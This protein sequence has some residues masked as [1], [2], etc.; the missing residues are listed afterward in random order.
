MERKS[1]FVESIQ[2]GRTLAGHLIRCLALLRK[3]IRQGLESTLLQPE[4][5][6]DAVTN[7]T[8]LSAA[9]VS[10]FCVQLL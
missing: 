8:H 4:E 5:L 7:D 9:G 1:R 6:E 10:P 3:R 2:G